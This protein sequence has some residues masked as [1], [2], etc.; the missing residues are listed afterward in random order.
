MVNWAHVLTAARLVL[1]FPITLALLWG[2]LPFAVALYVLAAIT[3]FFDGKIA[4][5]QGLVSEFGAKFDAG[6]D[7]VLGVMIFIW[8]WLVSP[9]DWIFLSVL[10]AVLVGAYIITALVSFAVVKRL[11]S[12]HLQT[13]RIG[14]FLLFTAFPIVVLF[15]YLV[16]AL[17]IAGAVVLAGRIEM[18]WV[19]LAK[20]G[21]IPGDSRG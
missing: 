3:D 20:K 8:L 4:R 16:P 2:S 11:V 9:N 7:M 12:L 17:S 10:F 13:G 5:R 6:V 19:L 14:T 21:S 1:I 18:I 15:G